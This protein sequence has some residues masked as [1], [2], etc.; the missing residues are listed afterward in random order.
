MAGWGM[1]DAKRVSWLDNWMKYIYIYIIWYIYNITLLYII[2]YIYIYEMAVSVLQAGK[3]HSGTLGLEVGTI[4]WPASRADSADSTSLCGSNPQFWAFLQVGVAAGAPSR[5]L[6][7]SMTSLQK[8]DVVK[9]FYWAFGSKIPGPQQCCGERHDWC[10]EEGPDNGNWRR[11]RN[12]A[13][14]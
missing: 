6:W 2:S 11:K 8:K 13:G 10:R 3:S 7:Y 12:V 9:E 5:I 4:P 14:M 1:V